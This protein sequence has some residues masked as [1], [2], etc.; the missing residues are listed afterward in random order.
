MTVVP[1]PKP[2]KR[3][4][5]E[6][7]VMLIMDVG[8]LTERQTEKRGEELCDRIMDLLDDMNMP[9]DVHYGMVEKIDLH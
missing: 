6:F 5:Y 3:R 2:P 9:M 4:K 8:E 7:R 1:F